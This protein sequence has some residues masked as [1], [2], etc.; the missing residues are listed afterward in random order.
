MLWIQ[1]FKILMKSLPIRLFNLQGFPTSS[2]RMFFF[3]T[4]KPLGELRY[5]KIWHDNSGPSGF[6]GWFLNKVTIKDLQTNKRH[7]TMI[8]LFIP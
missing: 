6:R 7:V 5:L 8:N 1:L 4:R 3:G 2:V